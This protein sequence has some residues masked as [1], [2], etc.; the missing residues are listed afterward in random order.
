MFK[1]IDSFTGTEISSHRVKAR[2]MAKRDRAN[3]KGMARFYIINVPIMALALVAL[4]GG[5]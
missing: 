2:A 3:G 1:V 4:L 5:I